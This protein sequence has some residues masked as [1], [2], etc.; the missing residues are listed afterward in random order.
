MHVT[1]LCNELQTWKLNSDPNC[2]QDVTM[3]LL[4]LLMVLQDKDSP[5]PPGFMELQKNLWFHACAALL[6]SGDGLP[7]FQVAFT[8]CT[9]VVYGISTCR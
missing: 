6:N 8:T 5:P 7:P 1:M 9:N 2:G 3:F 4:L